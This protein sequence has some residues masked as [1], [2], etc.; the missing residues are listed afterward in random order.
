MSVY[1][2]NLYVMSFYVMSVIMKIPIKLGVIMLSVIM[3]SVIMLIVI[4]MSIYV[5][6]VILQIVIRLN[7]IRLCVVAPIYL[8]Q[9]NLNCKVRRLKCHSHLR[10]LWQYHHWCLTNHFYPNLTV[11]TLVHSDTIKMYLHVLPNLSNFTV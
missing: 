5:T 9:G 10:R 6:S 11:L 4:V 2:M 7:V 3:L 1:V 8:T